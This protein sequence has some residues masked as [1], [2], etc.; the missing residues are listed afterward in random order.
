MK[1][2]TAETHCAQRGQN[3]TLGRTVTG[4]TVFKDHP[5][6]ADILVN[7]AGVTLTAPFSSDQRKEHRRMVAMTAIEVFLD[8]LRDRGGD[9]VNISPVASRRRDSPPTR[10][11]SGES[12]AGQKPS[13]SSSSPTSA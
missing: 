11:P 2:D 1:S 6:G 3:R 13:A 4:R 8:Q 9:L 12:T 7:D 5:V 10:R